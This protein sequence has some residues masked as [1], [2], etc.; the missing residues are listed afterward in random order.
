MKQLTLIT[1]SAFS[2]ILMLANPIRGEE[3]TDEQRQKIKDL[4]TEAMKHVKDGD[5][6]KSNTVLAQVLEVL[7]RPAA[8]EL[9]RNR[10][11]VFF[12]KAQNH[13]RLGEKDDGLS[14]LLRAI[15]QGFWDD[16]MLLNDP[17]LASLRAE[18]EFRSVVQ[19][20]KKGLGSVAVG[21]EDL[22][23]GKK[24]KAKDFEGKVLILDVWGT[25]CPPCRMEI[26][27]F[28]KLQSEYQEKGL[29]IVGL[30]W[31][32]RPPDKA[33]S[34]HVKQFGKSMGVNYSLTMLPFDRLDAMPNVQA[35]P[36]TFFVGRD[37]TVRETLMGYH[38][39]NALKFRVER[40][41]KEKVPERTAS[42]K[43][44]AA[45]TAN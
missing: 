9:D 16:Q 2:L 37:G 34:D 36:T 14:F 25:W 39:Y 18:K 26:P 3:L 23:T 10:S 19:K 31:E 6:Q 8:G 24:I 1:L 32:R 29:R 4:Y 22:A 44:A 20:A 41:L 7:P 27:H 33:L 30:T 17:A 38:D 12:V 40:L 21:L 43:P 11:H 45:A 35:F 28:M 5:Y 13:A 42:G 15:D